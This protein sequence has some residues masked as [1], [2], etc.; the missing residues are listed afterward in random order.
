MAVH[1]V[2]R[3]RGR[4]DRAVVPAGTEMHTGAFVALR[5]AILAEHTRRTGEY[6]LAA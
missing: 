5:D 3:F 2:R 4:R 1:L 6:Q